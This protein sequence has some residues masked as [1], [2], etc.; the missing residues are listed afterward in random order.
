MKLLLP[1]T[2][3]LIILAVIASGAVVIHALLRQQDPKA[4]WGWIAVCLLAP[5]L[6]PLAYLAFGI[7]RVR[8]RG[9][10]LM[11]GMPALVPRNI[12]RKDDGGVLDRPAPQDLP[13]DFPP[14]LR[15]LAALGHAL[16]GNP[17]TSGN[18]YTPLENGE[19][20]YP[21][22]LAAMDAATERVY[23][24]SYVFD[25]DQT[26]RR[27]IEALVRAKERGCDVRVVVDGMG[28]VMLQQQS[29]MEL[30]AEKGVPC[31]TFLKPGTSLPFVH[32]NL[33]CHQ[34]IL[35]VDDHIGFTGGM[36]ISDRH[37]VSDPGDKEPARDMHFQ[38]RGPVLRQL[39]SGFLWLW[40]FVKNMKVESPRTSPPLPTTE[41]RPH[42]CRVLVDGP[43]ESPDILTMILTNA[44]HSAQRQVTI[45]T[46]YYAPPPPLR[47][48]LQTAVVRG[49]AVRLVIPSR[50][51]K[52][53]M[54]SAARRNM[55]PLQAAGMEVFLRPPPFAH[56]KLFMVDGQYACI[57]SANFDT[58]SL[59]LN[60]ELNVE[61]FGGTLSR[62]LEAYAEEL[63]AASTPFTW[64]DSM[65]LPF[66]TR[67]QDGVCWLFSPYL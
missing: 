31:G 50:N 63:I 40:A 6:G 1:W 18:D 45:V 32:I 20:A 66:R 56:T 30:L 37:R 54:H 36:N 17:L 22:M 55:R 12:R 10:K 29:T 34:K 67:L 44:I 35:L 16:S 24:Q 27:F 39:E 33:R 58:R 47:N 53:W 57:G 11:R 3:W 59:R 51:D 46:P 41:A 25:P 7:N 15:N 9:S 19:A 42:F 60:F 8:L 43:H 13:G 26:G 14:H 64:H 21:A 52:P 28:G 49:V 23:L 62:T 2:W 61:A 48:A 5:L 38:V 4:A 65:A